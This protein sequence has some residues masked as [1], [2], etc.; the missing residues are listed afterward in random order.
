MSDRLVS[1]DIWETRV[2]EVRQPL[3]LGP[4]LAQ[5]LKEQIPILTDAPGLESL[6]GDCWVDQRRDMDQ[7]NV[8]DINEESLAVLV[9]LN[10][11]GT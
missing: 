8:F 9:L 4:Q 5:N 2:G 3:L 7:R 1:R 11:V 10:G 6:V